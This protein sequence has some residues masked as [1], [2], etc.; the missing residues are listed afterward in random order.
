MPPKTPGK[1][2]APPPQNEFDQLSLAK[3]CVQAQGV[4]YRLHTLD[5]RAGKPWPP[6]YFSRADLNRF[7]PAAGP[8]TFY[9]GE[10]LVGVLLEIFDDSWGSLNSSSRSLTKTQLQE[11]WVTLVAVPL[12]TVFAARKLNLSKI[13]TDLQMLSGDHAT[14]REWALALAR[15]P[16][17]IDGIYYTSRH[18]S[19]RFN[20][21]IF[22]QRAWP[23]EQFDASLAGPAAMHRSRVINPAGPLV[24][25]PSVLLRDH[26]ELMFAMAELEVAILP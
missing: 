14:S 22:N 23:P 2:N 13:G 12:I 5:R 16:L 11:W 4:F 3:L 18:D 9:V 17:K 6:I 25:G 7:D 19:D 10:T 1:L 26:P 21:A 8:G 20:L 15:H 24:Y